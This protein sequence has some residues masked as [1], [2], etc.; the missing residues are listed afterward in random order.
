M[1]DTKKKKKNSG[2]RK[3]PGMLSFVVVR[4]FAMIVAA[5]GVATVHGVLYPEQVSFIVAMVI[6]AAPALVHGQLWKWSYDWAGRGAS[7]MRNLRFGQIALGVVHV[8]LGGWA[9]SQVASGAV[10]WDNGSFYHGLTIAG[11]LAGVWETVRP[12]LE[13]RDPPEVKEAAERQAKRAA[14]KKAKAQKAKAAKADETSD[15]APEAKSDDVPA[16]SAE[17]ENTVV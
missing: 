4:Q 12:A 8:G 14:A 9:L 3:P 15:E 5:P 17:D 2:A 7:V 13:L 16:E 11:L 6:A 1:A 10:S